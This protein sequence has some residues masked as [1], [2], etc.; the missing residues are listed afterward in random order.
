MS[1]NDTIWPLWKLGLLLYPF[2]AAA[3]AI[4]L[5]MLGLI[6]PSI[7]LPVLSPVSALQLSVLLGLPATWAMAVW[8]RNLLR[9][10]SR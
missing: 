1:A 8:V 5:Y 2:T 9:E 4:N 10:A 6:A 3:V 7:G